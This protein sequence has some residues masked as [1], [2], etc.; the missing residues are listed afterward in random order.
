MVLRE[1]NKAFVG[2]LCK[3]ERGDLIMDQITLHQGEYE[4]MESEL[5]LTET[6]SQITDPDEEEE[7]GALDESGLV[8]YATMLSSDILTGAMKDLSTVRDHGLYI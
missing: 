2:F 1:L 7:E 8:E 6:G 5:N 4:E 3:D